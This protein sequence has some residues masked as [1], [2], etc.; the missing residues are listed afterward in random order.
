MIRS[1]RLQLADDQPLPEL[2]LAADVAA[3]VVTARLT[4][5]FAIRHRQDS[6]RAAGARWQPADCWD[7]TA[8]TGVTP[9]NAVMRIEPAP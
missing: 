6:R 2:H 3:A 9:T 1:I 7:R 8:S 4:R 5:R